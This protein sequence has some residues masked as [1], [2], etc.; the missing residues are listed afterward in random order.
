MAVLT[1]LCNHI[2]RVRK[3]DLHS[4]VNNFYTLK[5]IFT[6]LGTHYPDDTFC[7]KH[8]KFASKNY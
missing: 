4:S 5:R 6:I 7:Y 3:K 8:V 1:T 2:H